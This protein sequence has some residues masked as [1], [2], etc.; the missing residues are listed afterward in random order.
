[1]VEL[2]IRKD[3]KYGKLFIDQISRVDDNYPMVVSFSCN[4]ILTE[5]MF[6]KGN[7]DAL[8]KFFLLELE[9]NLKRTIKGIE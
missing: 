4:I 8:R 6:L 5:K 2:S 9:R 3:Y 7:E 1:M